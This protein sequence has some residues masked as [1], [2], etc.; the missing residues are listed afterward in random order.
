MMKWKRAAIF[1]IEFWI[2]GVI[3]LIVHEFGHYQ[4]MKKYEITPKRFQIG[5][6]P[7]LA[8]FNYDETEFILKLI[9]ALGYVRMDDSVMK[10]NKTLRSLAMEC[11]IALAG[12]RNT[13]IVSFTTLFLLGI[14][15]V[16][17]FNDLVSHVRE[18]AGNFFGFQWVV[19][20]NVLSFGLVGDIKKFPSVLYGT[21]GTGS[22]V[23]LW[24]LMSMLMTVMNFFPIWPLDGFLIA[25]LIS[26]RYV[27]N[28]DKFS[29]A[30][31]SFTFGIVLMLWR[32]PA[33]LMIRH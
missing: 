3:L 11:D 26:E 6:G 7:T 15:K 23:V 33:Q 21:Y 19:F 2:L 27:E 12:I 9:P 17:S 31:F 29:V 22:W 30:L 14:K 4:A 32:Y 1:S 18:K 5:I 10:E 28:F 16:K 25:S 24:I 20:I 13:G 8:R